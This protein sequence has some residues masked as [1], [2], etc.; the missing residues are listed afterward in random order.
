MIK[1]LLDITVLLAL[2]VL[3]AGCGGGAGGS[4]TPIGVEHGLPSIVRLM[5]IK[6]IAQTNSTI[7]LTTK[8][9]DGNGMPVPDVEVI[10]TNLTTL[11]VLSA[12]K[13]RT[14]GIGQ[15]TVT[16]FSSDVGFATIQAEVSVGTQL[17]RDRR[18][19]FFSPFDLS[20][21]A[22]PTVSPT[23]T[24]D[25][26]SNNNGIFNESADFILLQGAN[27]NQ[28]IVRATVRDDAGALA[29]GETVLF[30]T[31]SIEASFPLGASATTG[32][33]GEAS[34]LLQVDP[35]ILRSSQ[36][37]LTV[38]AAAANGA[39]NVVTFFLRPVTVSAVNVT[40]N[41]STVASAGTS[42]ITAS[43]TTSAG[44]AAP[45]GTAVN[46]TASSGGIA[47]FAQ[48]TAGVVTTPWTAP[49]VTSNSSAT[50]TA[51]SGGQSDN[52]TISITAPATALN[53]LPGVRNVVSPASNQAVTFT[54]SGGTA[55]YTTI[56]SDPTRVNNGG[57]IAIGSWS[58][59]TV[60]ATVMANACPGTVTLTVF[61]SA[62][63]SD[64]ATVTIV[65][66]APFTVSPPSA[67]LQAG[68]AGSPL[69]QIFT[70]SGGIAPY[71]ATS[72]NIS[73]IPA[74]QLIIPA[75]PGPFTFTVNPVDGSVA[76]STTVNITVTDAC[77]QS[78]QIPV[79]VT[80]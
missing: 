14:N 12:T 39:G 36:T 35:T 45:D 40:A 52:V 50:I 5:P 54:I 11:G 37:T 55:P 51:S 20:F 3:I 53:I 71:T 75:P 49:A 42:T 74:A 60:N 62:G 34:V 59:A 73:V 19:V 57:N 22:P 58:G 27:N 28:A 65:A 61:D 64:T 18:M 30:S 24:L 47:P 46:F 8:V 29:V 44:T 1:R 56:T 41:P 6:Q 68:P 63:A 4:A 69:T 78:R 43:V 32:T 76:A 16:I 80:P 13:A 23:L 10:Y 15:A 25:V 9:L 79:L 2:A 72:S 21:P 66:A 70:V 33:T 38:A 26:D 77:A 7:A 48:T 67:S 17:V 31:D